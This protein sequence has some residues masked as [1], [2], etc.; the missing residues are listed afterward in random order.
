M[1]FVET[2]SEAIARIEE[3][4]GQVSGRFAAEDDA[5]QQW[6]ADHCSPRAAGVITRMSVHALH[7]IDAIPADETVNIVGLARSSGVPKGTVSKIVRRFVA[8]DLVERDR[9]PG[10]RKEV[11]LR[12]TALGAEIQQAHRGLHREMGS[13][14][15]EFLDR[16][17]AADLEVIGRVLADLA[18]MPR[19]GLRF[20]PDLLDEQR[21]PVEDGESTD[22]Q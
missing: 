12:L 17:T 5:E 9:L 19:E 2:K 1:V 10:N 18:R 3:L 16:Y 20:R 22:A 11:H 7:L 14:I 6:L 15:Q 4:V 21:N 8:D 13:G